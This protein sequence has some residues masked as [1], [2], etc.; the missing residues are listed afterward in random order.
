MIKKVSIKNLAF[1]LLIFYTIIQAYCIP[2]LSPNYDEGSFASYGITILK[3]EGEKDI[4]KYDSKLPITAVNMLPRAV[5]QLFNPKLEKFTN[6]D[7]DVVMGRYI[8][9]LFSLLLGLLIFKWA[10]ALYNERTAI[11]C[12]A[13]YLLCPNFLANGIFVSSDIFAC[14]FMTLVFYYLWRFHKEQKLKYFLYFSI[15]AGLAQIS[16]F[17]MVH[18]FVLVPLVSLIAILFDSQ[19]EKKI[20]FK[21]ILFLSFIFLF[22]SWFLINAA[23][24]FY[25]PF[26]PL[27]QYEFLS[28]TFRQIQNLFGGTHLPI[29]LPSSYLGS[30]DMMF[31]SQQIGGGQPGSLHGVPYILGQSQVDGFWYY[32]FVVLF[33]KMPIPT[34]LIFTASIILFVLRFRKKEFLKNE[35]YLI[36][37]SA[38]F[39]VYLSFFYNTQI[40][41]RHIM[42]FF[43]LL[44]IF[45][46]KLISAIIA[47]RKQY[48]LYVLIALQAFS[49]MRFSPH[50]LPYT[51]EFIPDKKMAYKKIADTN[52]CYGE[53][54]KFLFKYL[55]ENKDIILSP[56]KPVAGKIILDVNDLLHVNPGTIGR[57]DWLH[58]LTPVDH[59]HSQYLLFDVR[60]SFI[61]SLNHK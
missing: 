40:G 56:E 26:L 7:D 33:F 21:K 19:K 61:D 15:A 60:Q 38:Y 25:Q 12:L 13:L 24:L 48:L 57:Y 14:F 8:S 37:P 6:A 58:G 39:I 5:E 36:I 34:L 52:L 44:F 17:S 11:F 50:F 9:L 27:S 43:P 20:R 59:V 3:L 23:H 32:Y 46:G 51:N 28:N 47:W 49:V 53:G 18:L 55:S 54:Q 4:L 10:E 30:M 16:K 2:R 45:S 29:P 22:T 31:Y 35:M 41:I 1:L 42:I